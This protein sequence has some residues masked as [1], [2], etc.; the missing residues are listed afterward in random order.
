MSRRT[1]DEFLDRFPKI[2][3]NEIKFLPREFG[4]VDGLSMLS[5]LCKIK[6]KEQICLFSPLAVQMADISGDSVAKQRLETKV[7]EYDLKDNQKAEDTVMR[8][9]AHPW[10]V[11]KFYGEKYLSEYHQD[12]ALPFVAFVMDSGDNDKLAGYLYEKHGLSLATLMAYQKAKGKPFDLDFVL[13]VSAR[14]AHTISMFDGFSHRFITP[15]CIFVEYEEKESKDKYSQFDKIP[16]NVLIG[17]FDIIGRTCTKSGW[18]PLEDY[19]KPIENPY[20]SPFFRCDSHAVGVLIYEMMMLN[21]YFPT[22]EMMNLDIRQQ[23]YISNT[24][25]KKMH[26][27][28]SKKSELDK[29]LPREFR[30]S[31]LFDVVGGLLQPIIYDRLS[32]FKASANIFQYIMKPRIEKKIKTDRELKSL[33]ISVFEKPEFTSLPLVTTS[34]CCIIC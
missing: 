3:H 25:T 9:I 22:A 26:D 19:M 34:S 20:S 33:A 23:R 8:P 27:N 31:H 29:F 12:Y 16:I 7:H 1:R 6:E 28:L 18:G 30:E 21:I 15:H 10:V 24:I 4:H 2:I 32:S 14:F 17:G 11:G 5:C 13:A